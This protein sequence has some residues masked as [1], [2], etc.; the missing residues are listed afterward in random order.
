M[1]RW[2][3][4]N[5]IVI[6]LG[7]CGLLLAAC[8]A[9][10]SASHSPASSAGVLPASAS[11]QDVA[12]RY[13]ELLRDGQSRAATSLALP[14]VEATDPLP[15]VGSQAISTTRPTVF[16]HAFIPKLLSQHPDLRG[17]GVGPGSD[18]VLLNAEW[19]AGAPG[20]GLRFVLLSRQSSGA[21][22]RVA[23]VG[24]APPVQ[25]P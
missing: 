5:A 20:A 8:S 17:L 2:F 9:A 16:A 6:A 14:G 10:P 12:K 19:Q 18:L 4:S 7:A 3:A 11:A 25:G 22:W 24:G 13:F 23:W 21:P 15:P 1:S